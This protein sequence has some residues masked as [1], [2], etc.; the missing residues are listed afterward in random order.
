MSP[1]RLKELQDAASEKAVLFLQKWAP[2]P[3]PQYD[4]FASDLKEMN[5]AVANWIG[6]AIICEKLPAP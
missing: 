6:A 2:P 3:G 4:Q 1:T 5:Q